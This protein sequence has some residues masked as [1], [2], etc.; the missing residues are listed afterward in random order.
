MLPSDIEVGDGRRFSL[1]ESGP[2]DMLDLIEAAG[3]AA[4][5]TAWMRYALMI[6][7]V[8]AIDGK[9]VLMPLTKNAVR[10]LAKRIG[11][12]G[13]DALARIHYPDEEDSD[14]APTSEFDT[15]KN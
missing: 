4:S 6:C 1:R 15:A 7:S 13:M 3:S 12:A 2:A 5:S 10:D 11:N 9:P 8:S 14:R